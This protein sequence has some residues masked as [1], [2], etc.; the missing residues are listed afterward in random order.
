MSN[1]PKAKIL[2]VDDSSTNRMLL[3]FTLEE[4]GFGVVEAE[5]GSCAV[6]I[7]LEEN[8]VAILM[9]INMPRMGGVKALEI[10]KNLNYSSP[11]IACSA[12]GDLKAIQAYLGKGFAAF[13]PKPIEP[14]TVAKQLNHLNISTKYESS[15]IEQS[16]QNK[17]EELKHHFLNSLP[18]FIERMDKI[19]KAKDFD[20]L[21]RAC[22]KLKANA[23]NFG[24]EKVAQLSK[25][26]EKAI[27]NS[28]Q[29]MALKVAHRMLFEL[30]RV[31]EKQ[32][33]S[34]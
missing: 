8:F 2:V 4:L 26:V 29:E 23:G 3:Q 33:R 16:H 20:E 7:A 13:I 22:H 19:I 9:D 32:S 25:E 12:E 30:L 10:L 17:I 27:I 14:E 11:I 34:N 5:D 6:E 31:N 28:Q 18:G 15:E 24:F 1:S 21:K